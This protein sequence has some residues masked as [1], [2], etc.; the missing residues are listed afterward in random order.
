MFKINKSKNMLQDVHLP[1]FMLISLR[2]M[3]T[4]KTRT[5][6]TV[7][8]IVIGVAAIVALTSVS[9][10]MQL[11]MTGWI[12]SSM[13]ADLIITGTNSN[14]ILPESRIPENYYEVITEID[15]VSSASRQLYGMGSVEKVSCLIQGVESDEKLNQ[16]ILTSGSLFKENSIDEVIIGQKLSDRLSVGIGDYIT[17]TSTS[18]SIKYRVMGVFQTSSLMMDESCMISLKAAQ[19]LFQDPEKVSMILVN[20]KELKDAGTIKLDIEGRLSGVK[21]IEQKQVLETVQYGTDI[22]T[23][24]LL[25]VASISM[26]VAGIGIMNTMLISVVERRRDIGIMKAV[27]MSR[28]QILQVFL[29]E[30]AM[31]GILGGVLGCASGV[32]IS[33]LSESLATS[34]FDIPM[35]VQF[36]SNTIIFSIIFAL[37]LATLSGLYPCWRA[38]SLRPVECLRYE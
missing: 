16:I 37:A 19:E 22:L 3:K 14:E 20:L 18:Q 2:N 10:G 7:L 8:G 28:T 21:V 38:T 4:R 35:S 12:K 25:M 30:A 11:Q 31:L 29:S 33:K 34:I 24:F 27:G 1:L 6:L 23:M 15:G 26:L 13:G 32:A 5:S 9:E 36:S 17:I